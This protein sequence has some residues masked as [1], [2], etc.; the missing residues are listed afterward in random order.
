MI[1]I[2]FASILVTALDVIFSW[3]PIVTELPFGMEGAVI[4]GVG[5]IKG[6]SAVVP[7]LL[8]PLALF[9]VFVILES[10][11]FLFY[12]VIFILRIL[13]IIG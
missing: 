2:F 13:R 11:F 7:F 6:L 5:I 4:T 1:L 3:L 10:V 12:L 8:L 9:P